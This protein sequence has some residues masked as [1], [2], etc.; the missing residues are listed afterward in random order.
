MRCVP[1]RGRAVVFAGNE[2][3]TTSIGPAAR[4]LVALAVSSYRTLIGHTSKELFIQ[5][6][7][8]FSDE[9]WEGFREAADASTNVRKTSELKL[10]RADAAA[11]RGCV[12]RE[13]CARHLWTKGY[14]PRLLTYPGSA[15]N[16]LVID[17]AAK[18]ARTRRSSPKC[19]HSQS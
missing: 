19:W 17:V 7:A 15:P 5:G 16:P 4:D 10:F 14:I 8:Q 13:R 3:A 6:K 12:H 2:G 9:E 18:R 11:T 1:R